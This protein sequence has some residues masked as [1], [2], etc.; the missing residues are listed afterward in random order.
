MLSM[1]LAS[2]GWG[3]WW[4]ALFLA[5]F[6]AVHPDTRSVAITAALF[7]VPGILVA[8][9]T[10]RAQRAWL[11]FVAIPLLANAGLLL[12]PLVVPSDLF[13]ET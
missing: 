5:K 7:A 12:L 4:A 10:V 9:Y 8:L 11:Y 2:L 6:T 3:C 1:T 13:H